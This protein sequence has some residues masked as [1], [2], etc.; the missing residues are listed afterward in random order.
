MSIAGARRRVIT[1]A[2]SHT[3]YSVPL[4]IYFQ[5]WN[6]KLTSA[7]TTSHISDLYMQLVLYTFSFLQVT[8]MMLQDQNYPDW[9]K[10]ARRFWKQGNNRIVLFWYIV[11]FLWLINW[12]YISLATCTS[13]LNAL[14][15]PTRRLYTC[16]CGLC[17]PLPGYTQSIAVLIFPHSVSA[18]LIRRTDWKS[19]DTARSPGEPR[20]HPLPFIPQA[21]TLK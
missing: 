18:P 10:A 15:I 6:A 2:H 17:S 12:P 21:M 19:M 14:Y 3:R 20:L 1:F 13:L 9:G 16:I 8:D 4:C 11:F 5:S 7:A